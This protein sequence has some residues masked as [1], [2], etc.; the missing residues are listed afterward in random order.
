[1]LHIWQLLNVNNRLQGRLSKLSARYFCYCFRT[2][3]EMNCVSFH[4]ITSDFLKKQKGLLFQVFM[5]TRLI[6]ATAH[7]NRLLSIVNAI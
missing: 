7:S 3:T 5:N 2:A 6:H 4:R 1:M